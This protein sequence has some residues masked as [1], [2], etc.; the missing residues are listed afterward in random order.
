MISSETRD[1]AE[2]NVNMTRLFDDPESYKGK[3][4]ILGGIIASSRNTKEGTY[5]EIVQKPLDSRGIPEDTDVSSG[6]FLII[7]QEYLD[8][9]IYARGKHITIA[10]EVLGSMMGSIGEMPYRYPLIRASEIHLV[11]V[12]SSHIPVTF[13]IGVMKSF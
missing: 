9:A 11:D 1:R 7:H 2:K 13:G 6:R 8:S 12:G 5:I 4:V 3:I 10:G